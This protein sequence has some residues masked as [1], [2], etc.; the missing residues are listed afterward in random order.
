MWLQ[1]SLKL[2][3]TAVEKCFKY[4][5]SIPLLAFQLRGRAFRKKM[6][7]NFYHL[8]YILRVFS[9]LFL[10]RIGAFDCLLML[11]IAMFPTTHKS[12]NAGAWEP[13]IGAHLTTGGGLV[14]DGAGLHPSES[15]TSAR[16]PQDPFL[17][18]GMYLRPRIQ[19]CVHLIKILFTF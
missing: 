4:M 7:S 9:G 11:A 2:P 5:P 17:L 16:R 18:T 15:S 13:W 8:F 14:Q 6:T 3:S 10:G 1:S 19:Q 12:H